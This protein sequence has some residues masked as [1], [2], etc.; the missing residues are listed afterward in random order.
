VGCGEVPGVWD[1]GDFAVDGGQRRDCGRLWRFRAAVVPVASVANSCGK[2]ALAGPACRRNGARCAGRQ[3][4]EPEL[5]AYA[6][7]SDNDS[8]CRLGGK[9]FRV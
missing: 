5:N 7:T 3:P 1:S 4:A 2:P 6:G 9:F 8:L